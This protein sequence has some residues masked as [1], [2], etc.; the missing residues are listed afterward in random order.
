MFLLAGT[1]SHSTSSRLGTLSGIERSN[2]WVVVIFGLLLVSNA[3]I[4]PMP[5]FFPEVFIVFCSIVIRTYS[6]G[7][8]LFLRITIC[9]YNA[10]LFLCVS[11]IKSAIIVR[12]MF[13]FLES[14]VLLTLVVIGIESLL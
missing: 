4:P 14:F 5:S 3:G 6:V 1:L 7:L 9:Y 10:Y 12:R 11:F 2:F 8:F 13:L